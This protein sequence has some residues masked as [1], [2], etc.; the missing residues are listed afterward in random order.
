[1]GYNVSP[2]IIDQDAGPIV[3]IE[4]IVA[5]VFT[6]PMSHT[7]THD[8]KRESAVVFVLY[9]S[10]LLSFLVAC[11]CCGRSRFVHSVHGVVYICRDF[12][13]F[14]SVHHEKDRLRVAFDASSVLHGYLQSLRTVLTL[15]YT[16]WGLR[17]PLTICS[18]VLVD[19]CT[20][21]S[22]D[23]FTMSTYARGCS[24]VN[25][26]YCVALLQRAHR[27][28]ICKYH[29][30]DSPRLRC[31]LD[32]FQPNGCVS[33]GCVW[34]MV[35]CVSSLTCG[36]VSQ[37]SKLREEAPEKSQSCRQQSCRQQSWQSSHV[38]ERYFQH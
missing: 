19:D 28:A 26:S 30:T 3:A 2:L 15:V 29:F 10:V 11:R 17:V 24:R 35:T 37:F 5:P 12:V 13:C 9:L 34:R 23:A 1:M 21:V 20:C 33:I 7:V 36:L 18:F 32:H 27:T 4:P 38:T 16:A 6:L 14:N 8:F 31:F 22:I 25:C